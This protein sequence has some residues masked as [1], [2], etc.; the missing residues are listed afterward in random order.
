[1]SKVALVPE[2]T[3]SLEI[4]PTEREIFIWIVYVLLHGSRRTFAHLNPSRHIIN[5]KIGLLAKIISAHMCILNSVSLHVV[6]SSRKFII[7]A[8]LVRG[9]SIVLHSLSQSEAV[10]QVVHT[11]ESFTVSVGTWQ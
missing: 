3:F 11:K 7:A 6:D 10:L 4:F 8:A 5:N 9:L 2:F 1:V